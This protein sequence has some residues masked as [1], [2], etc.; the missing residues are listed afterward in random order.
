MCRRIEGELSDDFAGGVQALDGVREPFWVGGDECEPSSSGFE[1]DEW[2]WLD[3]AIEEPEL[4]PRRLR[5]NEAC[6][7]DPT[8]AS[9]R[10]GALLESDQTER[11]I[12]QR[13]AAQ[14]PQLVR[15]C[16]GISGIGSQARE[17][18][19]APEISD[20]ADV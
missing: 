1:I 9:I 19:A 6:A 5:S 4:G 14:A 18:N 7:G 2:K 15:A 16:A 10:S 8:D 12:E 20:D 17:A 11:L 13:K 3:R